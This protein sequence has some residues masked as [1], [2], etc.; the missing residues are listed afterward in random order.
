MYNV[1]FELHAVLLKAMAHPKRLEIIHLLRDQELCVS[2]MQEMLG[3]PQANLS[4]HLQ[5]LRDARVVTAQKN[6]KQIRYCLAHP[7]LMQANDLIREVLIDQAVDAKVLE[8]LALT[9]KELVPL[10]HDPVC[11]MRLSPRT[12]AYV[13]TFQAKQYYF[14]AQGCRDTFQKD[15][16]SYV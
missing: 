1:I 2:Q 10:V 15:P 11:G 4:Q 3:L 8:E 16:Q 14:C 9:M 13:E 5:I 12:A 6:G 7:L